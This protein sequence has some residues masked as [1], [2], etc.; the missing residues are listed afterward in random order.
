MKTQLGWKSFIALGALFAVTVQAKTKPVLDC[1]DGTFAYTKAE[2][3]EVKGYPELVKVRLR[4]Q[5]QSFL[6]PLLADASPW[7]LEG[8]IEVTLM[9]KNCKFDPKDDFLMKCWASA[10]STMHFSYFDSANRTKPRSLNILAKG[11]VFRTAHHSTTTLDGTV[12]NR[13]ATIEFVTED[14]NIR[15]HRSKTK[16]TIGLRS[17][18][19]R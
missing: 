12:A 17:C 2:V 7:G 5:D 6:M 16:A 8:K 3:E 14:K 18:T 10:D 9:K 11:V 1:W 15:S 13:S 19:I 4:S